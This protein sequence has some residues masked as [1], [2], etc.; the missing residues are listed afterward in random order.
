MRA[1]IFLAFSGVLAHGQ[2]GAN[3]EFDLTNRAFRDIAPR[4]WDER[5]LAR[6]LEYGGSHAGHLLENTLKIL[7]LSA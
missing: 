3:L 7:I 2:T 1:A 5:R 6:R 4:T